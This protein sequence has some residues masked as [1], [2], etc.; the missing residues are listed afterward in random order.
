MSPVTTEREYRRL[1]Q[2]RADQA[3][4]RAAAEHVRREPERGTTAALSEP[5][6]AEACGE[7]LDLFADGLDGFDDQ[8]RRHVA[9]VARELTG[10]PMDQPTRRRTRRR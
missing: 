9:R 2:L 10:A 8:L 6:V 4:I 3:V 1:D 5:H 7:L